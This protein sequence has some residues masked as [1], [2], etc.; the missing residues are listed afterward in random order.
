MVFSAKLYDASF[1][2]AKDLD[3]SSHP[4]SDRRWRNTVSGRGLSILAVLTE[5][6][7]ILGLQILPSQD[8]GH[9][10]D[11]KINL[12]VNVFCEET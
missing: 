8:M 1:G 5:E 12:I 6:Y 9:E 4:L 11:I 10:S 7:L 3:S 2:N